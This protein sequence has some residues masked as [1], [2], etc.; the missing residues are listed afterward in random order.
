MANPDPK[1]VEIGSLRWVVTIAKRTQ[2]PGTTGGMIEA[3]SD[4]ITVRADVQPVGPM[5]FYGAAQTD[6][7]ITHKISIR[8]LDFIDTTHVL[9]RDVI[10]Q[11]RTT[12]REVFRIRR[13]MEVDG[14]QRFLSL[15][16]EMERRI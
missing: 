15:E 6:T 16:C 14:R 4:I 1:R 7:P 13:M 11:D 10:R 12:R 8:W 5:V 2:S 3:L 9:Y